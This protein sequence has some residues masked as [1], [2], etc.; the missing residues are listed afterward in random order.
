VAPRLIPID[1][2][3][4][5]G[6]GQ[7]LRTALALSCVTGQGFEMTRIRA[8]RVRPGLRPQHLACVR[9]AAMACGAKVGGAFDGS[10]DLRFEPGPLAA[11]DFEFEI[12]TAGATSLVV[13]TVLAPLATTGSG[14]RVRVTGGTHVPRSPSFDY[15]SRHWAAAVEALGLRCTFA[16]ERAGFYPRGGGALSA[17]VEPW[18]RP[19]S[20]EL[21]ER[22]ALVCVRGVSGE[23]RLKGEVAKRQRDA[24][25]ERLWEARRLE[26]QW[27]VVSVPAG[28]P[29]SFLLIEALFEKSRAA[30][31]FLGERGVRAE[32]LGDRAARRLLRFLE[33]EGAVDPQLADQLA[34]PLALSGGLGR[35]TTCEVTRHLETVAEVVSV[36]GIP[37]ATWGRRGGPGGLEVGRH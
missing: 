13:Q 4:G 9:A 33:E 24:A 17:S 31:A 8:G 3:R 12:A 16:L 37:A 26:A 35:V 32:Q 18:Q 36:F 29:G 25:Q 20:L 7:I 21:S 2:A 23:G 1:G 19:A 34:V 6:G 5:E 28:S 30:F 10:P 27:D 15:L 14:S 22:G 11:G